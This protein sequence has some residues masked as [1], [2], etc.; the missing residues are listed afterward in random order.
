MK[1]LIATEDNTAPFGEDYNRLLMTLIK[2]EYLLT[3]PKYKK[4]YYYR[5]QIWASEEG[6]HLTF[7]AYN[8]R[9]GEPC[10]VK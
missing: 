2:F 7:Q 3:R 5:N 6:W 9:T 10:I 4:H 8:R 1:P